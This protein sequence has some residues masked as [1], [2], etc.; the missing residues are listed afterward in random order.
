[1]KPS[2]QNGREFFFIRSSH[3]ASLG[4]RIPSPRG[5]LSDFASLFWRHLLSPSVTPEAAKGGGAC[6]PAL[7]LWRGLAV[8]DFAASDVD[9]E[10]GELGWI[11][12]AF[13]SVF[14]HDAT[15]R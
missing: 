10:L 9:H 2:R 5:A 7:F 4:F 12:R 11:A 15:M 1:M 6:M 13:E 3:K 14:W 8:F